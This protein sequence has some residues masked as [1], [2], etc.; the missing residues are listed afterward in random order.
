MGDSG[1]PA[2][3][4]LVEVISRCGDLAARLVHLHVDDGSGRCVVCSA[5]AQSARYV[6]P[7]AIRCLATRALHLQAT[8]LGGIPLRKPPGMLG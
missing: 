1:D 4:E 3:P 2:M 6:Y 7:C 5:G 8:R